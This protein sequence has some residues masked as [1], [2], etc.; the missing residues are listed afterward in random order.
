MSAEPTLDQMRAIVA[1]VAGRNGD[2]EGRPAAER[3][4]LA[5]L[6]PSPG[7]DRRVR[8]GVRRRARPDVD[9]PAGALRSVGTLFEL[10]HSKRAG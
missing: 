8:G 9:L 5:R 7:D 4:L 3:R 6:G 10:I 1:R 2:F